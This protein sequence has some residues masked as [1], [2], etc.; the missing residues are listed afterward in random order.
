MTVNVQRAP[1]RKQIFK[2]SFSVEMLFHF[3]GI[4]TTSCFCSCVSPWARVSRCP[5]YVVHCV[6]LR[7]EWQN[8]NRA[9][10]PVSRD[11]SR[12]L[13]QSAKER[14]F[15]W[16]E[17]HLTSTHIPEVYNLLRLLVINLT[18]ILTIFCAVTQLLFVW[19]NTHAHLYSSCQKGWKAGIRLINI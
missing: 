11:R 16:L 17:L 8:T 18:W 19:I 13:A 10:R 14:F 4:V 15:G 3:S 5:V 7:E 12:A 9:R 6:W 1:T 2:I